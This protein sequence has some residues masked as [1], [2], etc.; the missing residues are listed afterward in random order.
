MDYACREQIKYQ[1]H[2]GNEY[3]CP[4]LASEPRAIFRSKNEPLM[5]E[6]RYK[7]PFE[8]CTCIIS[9]S[10]R[11]ER[12]HCGERISTCPF[13][14][15][16][17]VL[18]SF[19]FLPHKLDDLIQ[20]VHED[21][22]KK[23]IDLDGAFPVTMNF[24]RKK[25]LT[26]R[27]ISLVINSKLSMP[28]ESVKCFQDLLNTECPQPKDFVSQLKGTRPLE[29]ADMQSFRLVWEEL[30]MTNWLALWELYVQLDVLMACDAISLYFE[31]LFQSC[32]IH[33]L[34]HLTI[35]LNICPYVAYGRTYA[36]TDGHM[37]L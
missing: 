32:K 14:R 9:P 28:Y 1:G 33:P 21:R 5:L 22:G 36:L 26:S 6:W 30:Q 23:G 18:D 19:L 13:A 17:R 11:R 29:P 34:W 24:L 8:K 20:G 31:K 3:T 35:R 15:K 16:I 27:Q 37:L 7:C 2:D 12:T 4:L 25:K 10:E